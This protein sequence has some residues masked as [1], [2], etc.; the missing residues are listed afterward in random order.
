MRDMTSV[1]KTEVADG[2][3]TV[4]GAAVGEEAGGDQW[5]VNPGWTEVAMGGMSAGISR[6]K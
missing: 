5:T 4:L 1:W 6:P 2:V 3:V